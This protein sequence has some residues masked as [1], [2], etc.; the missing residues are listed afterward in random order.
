MRA[1][2]A[3]GLPESWVGATLGHALLQCDTMAK[4]CAAFEIFPG[5]LEL[6]RKFPGAG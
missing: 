1:T 4:P 5:R 6:Y 3:G 2:P